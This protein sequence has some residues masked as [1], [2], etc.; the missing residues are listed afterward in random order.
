MS[1]IFSKI[2]IDVSQISEIKEASE[3]CRTQGIPAII[4]HPSL[5]SLAIIE[6]GSQK[7]RYKIGSPIDSPK[8]ELE[9]V[10]K[11]RH[12]T[13]DTL[14]ADIFEIS[15]NILN[16]TVKQLETYFVNLHE[17]VRSKIS[18]CEIRYTIVGL[19]KSNVESLVMAISNSPVPAML[20]NDM[21]LKTQVKLADISAH[22]NYIS[23]I[24]EHTNI[25]LKIGGNITYQVA[26]SLLSEFR[27]LYF[28]VNLSQANSINKE[29][30][31]K[32]T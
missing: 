22:R 26:E 17:F 5:S 16:K 3:L 11:F 32:D 15:I 19:D 12:L 4:V 10:A 29:F 7:G 21:P 1:I 2:E 30:Y 24:R 23:Y 6:K 27:S 25:P 28:A 13:T 14:E 31:K 9:G 18:N 20:R 8:G